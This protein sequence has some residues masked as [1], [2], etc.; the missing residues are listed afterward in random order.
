[1]KYSAFEQAAVEAS[2]GIKEIDAEIDKLRAR[3]ELLEVLE[4]LVHQLLTVLPRNA[5]AIP[6]GGSRPSGSAPDAPV[7]ERSSFANELAEHKSD[8]PRNEEW[9]AFVQQS[10]SGLQERK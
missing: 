10:T 3:K 1:M 2:A 4:T 6:A 9:P 7:P 8:A 5:G